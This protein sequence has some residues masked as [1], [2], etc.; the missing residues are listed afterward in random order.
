M[1]LLVNKDKHR[2]MNRKR[3][4]Q[5]SKASCL[6]HWLLTYSDYEHFTDQQCM[7]YFLAFT[8]ELTLNI[9]ES[10]RHRRGNMCRSSPTLVHRWMSGALSAGVSSWGG[11]RE[12]QNMTTQ[13][14]CRQGDRLLSLF[15]PINPR[16]RRSR[17]WSYAF[18]AAKQIVIWVCQ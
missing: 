5:H 3:S 14:H 9:N 4:Q 10:C 1:N 11:Q 13:P 15:Q 7:A 8:L 18:D 6:V 16:C 17:W 2:K 12:Y